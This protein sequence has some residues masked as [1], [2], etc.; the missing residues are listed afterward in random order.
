[1]QLP[2]EGEHIE[3]VARRHDAKQCTI[4]Q[5]HQSASASAAHLHQGRKRALLGCY[6]IV[7]RKRAHDP[8]DWHG[9]PKRSVE[10]RD[11]MCIDAANNGVIFHD[12]EPEVVV[13][14]DIVID[15]VPGQR[16]RTLPQWGQGS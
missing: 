9:W 11:L 4:M 15:E 1:M 10:R 6:Y 16:D 14:I 12:R 2:L 5:H 13:A 8:T 3:Q 7:A